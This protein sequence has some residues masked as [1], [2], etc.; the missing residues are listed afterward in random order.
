MPSPIQAQSNPIQATPLQPGGATSLGNSIKQSWSNT[1]AASKPLFAARVVANLTGVGALIDLAATSYVHSRAAAKLGEAAQPATPAR[2]AQNRPILPH[3]QAN[4]QLAQDYS[5]P[6]ADTFR[7]LFASRAAVA[8]GRLDLA[9][10]DVASLSRTI[11]RKIE[12]ESSGDRNPVSEES[13]RNIALTQIDKFIGTKTALLNAITGQNLPPAE[14]GLVTRFALTHDIK[15]PQ[16]LIAALSLRTNVATLIGQLQDP[17][18]SRRDLI[19][20]LSQYQRAYDAAL[21]PL[22]IGRTADDFGADDIVAFGSDALE[23]GMLLM[24]AEAAADENIG[25]F[26]STWQELFS[27][28]KEPDIRELRES[29]QTAIFNGEGV[30]M[31]SFAKLR[32]LYDTL[33]LVTH[34]AGT[35]AGENRDS[36]REAS[37][38]EGNLPNLDAVPAE[39]IEA[40]N[41]GGMPDVQY[42][43]GKQLAALTDPDARMML[44]NAHSTADATRE[45]TGPNAKK[46]TADEQDAFVARLGAQGEALS[47]SIHRLDGASGNQALR[48]R[49]IGEL[50]GELQ[51]V[52]AKLQDPALADAVLR[53]DVGQLANL[54]NRQVMSNALGNANG[55]AERT[56]ANPARLAA[57]E[58]AQFLTELRTQ[59]DTLTMM[60]AAVNGRT[61]D[62]GV[63]ARVSAALNRQLGQI[64]GK[65]KSPAFGDLMRKE[66]ETAAAARLKA[67]DG[68]RP[69]EHFN[70]LM[71][72][73]TIRGSLRAYLTSTLQVENLDFYD[74]IRTFQSELGRTPQTN[75]PAQLLA[76]AA[77]IDGRFIGS[78]SEKDIN[79]AAALVNQFEQQVLTMQLA[80]PQQLVTL[81][82]ASGPGS[83]QDTVQKAADEVS[84][85]LRTNSGAK[86]T[87]F[88]ATQQASAQI[89]AGI[90]RNLGSHLTQALTEDAQKPLGA[91]PTGPKFPEDPAAETRFKGLAANFSDLF[92]ADFLR[93]GV[94]VGDR[95]ISAPGNGDGP[96]A[97]AR[98]QELVDAFGGDAAL[99]GNVTRMLGQNISG[100]L[101][102]G[103]YLDQFGQ[104]LVEKYNADLPDQDTQTVALSISGQA[105]GTY[106]ATY[107][108]SQQTQ[109][110]TE[111]RATLGMTINPL[112]LDPGTPPTIRLDRF[113]YRIGAATPEPTPAAASAPRALTGLEQL[114]QARAALRR[115]G[116]NEPV[117][118]DAPPPAAAQ[119]GPR[120]LVS[121]PV[122]PGDD[123]LTRRT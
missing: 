8:G 35:M 27:L 50:N 38:V 101:Q 110:N 100:A 48:E 105:D 25:G 23:L 22:V 112:T 20:G 58:R 12:M 53:R 115:D 96:R 71:N 61:G 51:G 92:M 13:A 63:R 99:A 37:N 117:N 79:L 67:P 122:A 57:P 3:Q 77:E 75:T 1:F 59:R 85:L 87:Q 26:Q 43:T 109:K 121:T 111:L 46:M 95:A 15:N 88:F 17:D 118:P 9:S 98:L 107:A 103:L 10:V 86:F 31:A 78:G 16:T 80:S 93:N 40:L 102:Q 72:D 62:D 42:S 70:N 83:F 2:L 45:I 24:P 114:I 123:P 44:S 104:G 54:D 91:Q 39:I 106:R 7:N 84:K 82:S 81:L 69:A 18:L 36:I 66:M 97:L 52:S 55:A 14:A 113:D 73:P 120:P 90:E 64:E 30:S 11:A 60:R 76:F 89:N 49:I 116:E 108:F 32:S 47:A 119:P 94:T 21:T 6:T 74:A 4:E 56:S 19:G 68:T 41:L 28:V 34:H 5:E 33:G 29:L 65:L